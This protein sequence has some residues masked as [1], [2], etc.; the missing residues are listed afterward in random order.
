MDRSLKTRL[1]NLENR[2]RPQAPSA[3]AIRYMDETVE[4]ALTRFR[5]ETGR[6][7]MML[8]TYYRKKP[9]KEFY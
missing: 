7:P 5:V 6:D 2:C 8:L 9:P 4:E 3:V 1:R